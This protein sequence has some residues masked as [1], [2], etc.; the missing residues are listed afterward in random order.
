MTARLGANLAEV[1]DERGDLA[2]RMGDERD[3][4]LDALGLGSLAPVEPLRKAGDHIF[5]RVRTRE[6][7]V[8]LAS[9]GGLQLDEPLLLQVAE[10][11]DDPASLLA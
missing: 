1:A 9:V 2:A 3:D 4:A 11:G 7:R 6:Q 5:E 8:P 10:G